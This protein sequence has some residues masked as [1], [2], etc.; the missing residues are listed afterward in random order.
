M[1]G[2][3][4]AAYVD[5]SESEGRLSPIASRSASACNRG[6]PGIADQDFGNDKIGTG[7]AEGHIEM[8]C[9]E[10]PGT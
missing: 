9:F 3:S 8:M 7:I 10:L 4:G 6:L 2:T 1:Q 5:I